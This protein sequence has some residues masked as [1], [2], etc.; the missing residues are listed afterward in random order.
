[1]LKRFVWAIALSILPIAAL[2]PVNHFLV[3]DVHNIQD[4]ADRNFI[5]LV[6]VEA[7]LIFGVA[8]QIVNTYFTLHPDYKSLIRKHR[9]EH[10]E[11]PDQYYNDPKTG[12]GKQKEEEKED[13]SDKKKQQQEDSVQK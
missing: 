6:L 4:A 8:F 12:T 2:V 10:P 9:T 13:A 3:T 11:I 7:V 1:L 5:S